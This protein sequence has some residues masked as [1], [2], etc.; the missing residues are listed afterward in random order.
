MGTVSGFSVFNDKLFSN[1]GWLAKLKKLIKDRKVADR[2][3]R[4]D[5][6]TMWLLG[7]IYADC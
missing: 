4:S 6:V 5:L 2:R 3:D 1:I 7:L